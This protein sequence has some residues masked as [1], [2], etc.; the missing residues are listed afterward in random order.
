MIRL[1]H[2]A[3]ATLYFL[4]ISSTTQYYT[5]C[6]FQVPCCVAWAYVG[7]DIKCG[8]EI[9]VGLFV[10]NNGCARMTQMTQNNIYDVID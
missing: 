7:K 1:G 6:N 8:R 2:F 9:P 10:E 3:C 5:K 4:S